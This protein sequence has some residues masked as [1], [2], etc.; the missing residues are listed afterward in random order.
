MDALH[1]HD[2]AEGMHADGRAE[3]V[4]RTGSELA[5]GDDAFRFAGANCYYL[6][7]FAADVDLRPRVD[8]VL[9][10][11]V[12]LG[13][14]VIRTWAFANGEQWNALQPRPGQYE[15]RVLRGLDYVLEGARRRGLRL[16]LALTNFWPDYGGMDQ[17][18]RWSPT[19]TRRCDFYG[20]A[21]C[22]A[23][24]ADHI[25]RLTGR[26]NHLSGTAYRD[27]PTIMA[28]ELANEPRCPDDLSGMTLASWLKWAGG[29]LRDYAPKQLV[30]TGSEG[31]FAQTEP[32]SN[33]WRWRAGQ[34][35][36]FAWHHELDVIDI[37]SAHIYPDHW[38]LDRVGC[39]QWIDDHLRTAEAIEKPVV[40]GEYGKRGSNA[41]RAAFFRAWMERF[42][43]GRA[44][45]TMVWSLYDDAYPDYDGFGIYARR[46]GS[47]RDVLERHARAM[48]SERVLTPRQIRP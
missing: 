11:A 22:R 25:R 35:C 1:P 5:L 30:S 2:S 43:R 32:R 42:E 44:S 39:L 47:I 13:L 6:M 20:D 19:A 40:F 27:D 28:W 45:G 26:V 7:V 41:T 46:P 12:G 17:Y 33:P 15:E 3:F 29:L 37:A 4:R 8:E 16:T 48:R 14:S 24:Y 9:D 10:T 31:F 38:Y 23:M 36:D 21:R 34:G 18:V